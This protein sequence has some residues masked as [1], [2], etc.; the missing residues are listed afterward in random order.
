MSGSIGAGNKDDGKT[1]TNGA[2]SVVLETFSLPFVRVQTPLAP[3]FGQIPDSTKTWGAY[4]TSPNLER[5]AWDYFTVSARGC[6]AMGQQS[7]GLLGNF[8]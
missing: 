5:P 2:D 7:H 1:E 8:A 6:D 4:K 3:S